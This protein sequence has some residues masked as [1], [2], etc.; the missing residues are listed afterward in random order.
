MDD[1]TKGSPIDIVALL[2]TEPEFDTRGDAIDKLNPL[3]SDAWPDEG[4]E[5]G[6][7]AEVRLVDVDCT[8]V[9]AT[10]DV[11]GLI[12]NTEL[13]TGEGCGK[14]LGCDGVVVVVIVGGDVMDIDAMDDTKSEMLDEMS[15][16]SA[17]RKGAQDLET[18]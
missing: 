5:F 13:R 15:S 7:R 10:E 11:E 12:P 4:T 16:V 18:D 17:K 8:G 1:D 9:C 6:G 2:S 14:G 3:R